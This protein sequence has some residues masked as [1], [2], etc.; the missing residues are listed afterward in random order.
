MFK[1]FVGQQRPPHENW[2]TRQRIIDRR[3]ILDCV[4]KM[5]VRDRGGRW[6]DRHC[7]QAH[8]ALC[9]PHTVRDKAEGCPAGWIRVDNCCYLESE[10]RMDWHR[11]Q[12]VNTSNFLNL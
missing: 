6:S 4:V 1:W 8:W 3:E 12:K 9:Q 7:N 11:A 2:D 10:D 5:P